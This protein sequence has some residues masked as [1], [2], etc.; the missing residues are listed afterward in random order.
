MLLIWPGKSRPA[1]ARCRATNWSSYNAAQRR[2]GSLFVWLDRE[3]DWP[4]PRRGRP[5]RPETVSY[6]AIQFCLGLEVL[7]GLAL[8]QIEA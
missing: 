3:M 8:R 4:A 7:F 6:A 1:P 5:G 2:R